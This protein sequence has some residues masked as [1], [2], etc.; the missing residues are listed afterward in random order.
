MYFKF[1]EKNKN[2]PRETMKTKLINIFKMFH[3]KH[4]QLLN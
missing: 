4:F 1:P 3:G 2:V